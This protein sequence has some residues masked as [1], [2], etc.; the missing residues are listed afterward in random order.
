M[1]PTEILALLVIAAVVAWVVVHALTVE[2]RREGEPLDTTHGLYE[3][4]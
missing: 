3:Q 4:P 2:A 1:T